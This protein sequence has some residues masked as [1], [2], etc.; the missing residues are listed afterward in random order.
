MKKERNKLMHFITGAVILLTIIVNIM[1]RY[2]HMF[3]Y[4]HGTGDMVPS[5]DIESQFGLTLNILFMIPIVFFLFSIMIYL[6]NKNHRFIPNL[7]TLALAFGSVAIIS[8]GSGRIEFHFSIFM[9][10]AALGY[11][12]EIKLIALMTTIFAIQHIIGLI[13]VPELVFG[14]E[15]YMFSMFLWHAVFLILTS[16][17]VSW[18]VYSGKKIEAYY[19][20][21]QQEQRKNIVE[22]IVGRLSTTSDQISTVSKTLSDNAKQSYEA[23]G[24]LAASM[25]EASGS[26]E[27]Q[28]EI[29]QDHMNV[30]TQIDEGIKSINQ[31]AQEVSANSDA[32]AKEARHGSELIENLLMQIKGINEDVDDS[33]A[34][35]KELHQRSQAI[36]GIV[37]VISDIADQTNLLSLNASIESA[38]AGEYG[39]GFAVVADEVK[40]LAEQSL[41]SS[42]NISEII[43]QILVVTNESVESME[44]VK[45]STTEGLEVAQKSN[46][47]FH[48]IS[49]TSGDVASQVQGVSSLTED[50]TSYSERVNAAM[51]QVTQ[52]ARE[53]VSGT[54]DGIHSTDKQYELTET[55]LE[56]SNKLNNLTSE[57]EGVIRTLRSES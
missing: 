44:N 30:I 4:S 10:V 11:Y 35:V 32:S 49:E 3:D 25:K 53:S 47:V 36:E 54:R 8:G 6:K 55:T 27:Q 7:L 43:Q 28:L 39:K 42:K 9:V 2:F 57:L 33:Y 18:Q 16:S 19:Q 56:V 24:K 26:T 15:Q 37:E 21:K 45:S 23:S 51:Q 48:H 31:T 14:M 41:E 52:S 5:A 20:Q 22:D 50:L 40:K 29:V 34:K 13:Y 17:A 1:G 12:Q 38:R 46:K